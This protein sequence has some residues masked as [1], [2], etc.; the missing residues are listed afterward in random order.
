MWFL[1]WY[2]ELA[3]KFFNEHRLRNQ[4]HFLEKGY[5]SDLA[6]EFLDFVKLVA[7]TAC[8]LAYRR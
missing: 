6:V 4:K 8:L 2:L 5:W 7:V 1:S 3:K